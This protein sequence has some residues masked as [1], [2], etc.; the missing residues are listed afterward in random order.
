MSGYGRHAARRAPGLLVKLA[1]PTGFALLLGLAVVGWMLFSRTPGDAALVR[2]VSALPTFEPSARPPVPAP[3]PTL[4]TVTEPDL[5]DLLP[6][7]AGAATKLAGPVARL[8]WAVARLNWA[9]MARCESRGD[10]RSVNRTGH[11]GLYQFSLPAWRSVG[12]VGRPS[13]APAVE[14][15][16]RAQL[17]YLKAGHRWRAQWPACG[18]RLFR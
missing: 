5:P 13:D 14:Q 10:S 9:A 16:I 17:L 2:D 11:Y 8:N 4:D 7:T 6:K 3:V 1:A 18:P 15:T 12:G